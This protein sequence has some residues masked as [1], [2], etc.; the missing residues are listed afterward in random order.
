VN[1]SLDANI[2]MMWWFVWR[3]RNVV[4]RF[5]AT[6]Y[7]KNFVEFDLV[8]EEIWLLVFGYL[9]SIDDIQSLRRVIGDMIGYETQNKTKKVL[10]D[11]GC[12][13]AKI[14]TELRRMNN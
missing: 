13:F 11:T 5:N 8:P 7:P 14:F 1:H 4:E 6:F 2:D 9:R 12:R 3:W 10:D